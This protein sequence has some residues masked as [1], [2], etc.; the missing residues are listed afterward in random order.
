MLSTYD[1]IALSESKI[2]AEQEV[3][4]HAV[5]KSG[6]EWNQYIGQIIINDFIK[7]LPQYDGSDFDQYIKDVVPYIQLG[8]F[9]SAIAK[10]RPINI[11]GLDDIKSWLIKSLEEGEN[12]QL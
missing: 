9:D 2:S 8:L 3:V 4:S 7:Q 5:T 10:I 12:R 6:L 1:K 11:N